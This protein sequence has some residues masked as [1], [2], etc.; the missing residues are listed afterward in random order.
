MKMQVVEFTGPEQL[1][2]LKDMLKDIIELAD[3]NVRIAIDSDGFKASIDGGVWSPGY[4]RKR[5]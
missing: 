3:Y 5:V 2:Q 4:P 1:E